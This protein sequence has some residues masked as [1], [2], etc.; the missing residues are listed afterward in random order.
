LIV[1]I[2]R[3]LSQYLGFELVVLTDDDSFC[4]EE[5]SL[6]MPDGLGIYSYTRA[7]SIRLRATGW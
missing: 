1:G 2:V 6:I 5:A 7:G 3:I 4:H